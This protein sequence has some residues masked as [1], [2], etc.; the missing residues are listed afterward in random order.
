MSLAGPLLLNLMS[1]N[2]RPIDS[3]LR[4]GLCCMVVES[5]VDFLPYFLVLHPLL[6]RSARV[7][8]AEQVDNLILILI[9][10][11]E[12]LFNGKLLCSRVVGKK[13][14]RLP[15]AYLT[16]SFITSLLNLPHGSCKNITV[17]AVG[18][19]VSNWEE[20]ASGVTYLEGV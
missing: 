19:K 11:A 16:P 10:T 6:K 8:L 20:G 13:I 2:N 18:K 14:S 3:V 12:G 7:H 4:R 1:Q 17:L 15:V 9:G 5:R